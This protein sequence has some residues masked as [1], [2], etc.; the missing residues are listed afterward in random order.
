MLAMGLFFL[1]DF[2]LALETQKRWTPA[3]GRVTETKVVSRWGRHNTTYS[4]FVSYDYS[5]N[6]SIHSSGPQ[7]LNK[8][9]F[10]FTESGA[11]AY[12]QENYPQ[13]KS[14][15]TYYNPANPSQS[16]LGLAGAP[17]VALPIVF[18]LFAFGV[19]YLGIQ[20]K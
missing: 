14:L 12:L 19:F 17:Y 20:E 5:A 4:T 1:N 9:K 8:Y 10:Y 18:I 3:T 6:E 13:G 7:Q 16:S 2:R 11:Y 15:D